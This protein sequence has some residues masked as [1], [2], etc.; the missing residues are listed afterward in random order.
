[1]KVKERLQKLFSLKM[2]RQVLAAEPARGYERVLPREGALL[3]H[4]LRL[5]SGLGLS[6]WRCVSVEF[7]MMVHAGQCPCS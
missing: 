6:W 5:E 4:V 3:R 1:M 2:S 7:P